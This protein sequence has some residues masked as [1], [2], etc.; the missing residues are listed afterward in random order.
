MKGIFSAGNQG[1]GDEIPCLW[2][3]SSHQGIAS[4]PVLHAQLLSLAVRK[5][6]EALKDLSHD[7]CRG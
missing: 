1:T 3:G 7:V 4:F 5:A 6:A 2:P